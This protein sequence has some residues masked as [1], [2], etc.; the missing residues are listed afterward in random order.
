MNDAEIRELVVL[1]ILPGKEYE[2]KNVGL[3][4]SDGFVCLV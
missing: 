1:Y 3:C 4:L 2:V